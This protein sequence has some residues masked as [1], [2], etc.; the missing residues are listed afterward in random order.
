MSPL[1]PS[2]MRVS[3]LSGHFYCPVSIFVQLGVEKGGVQILK[4]RRGDP[5]WDGDVKG[6]VPEK[7]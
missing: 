1:W 4:H 7:N 2:G 3:D 5:H 6:R